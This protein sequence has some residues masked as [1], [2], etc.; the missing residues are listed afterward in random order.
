M[1]RCPMW[2]TVPLGGIGWVW[3]GYSISYIACNVLNTTA[4]DC[5]LDIKC[6]PTL[7]EFPSNLKLIMIDCH[8]SPEYQRMSLHITTEAMSKEV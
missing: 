4:G 8:W 5:L 2:W 3:L 7:M 1:W 6:K